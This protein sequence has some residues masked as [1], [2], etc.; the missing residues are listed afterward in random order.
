[1]LFHVICQ[2]PD[3][4]K[5]Y[6]YA[7]DHH[8]AKYQIL[9]HKQQSTGSKHFNYARDV[10]KYSSDRTNTHKNI[11]KCNPNKERKILIVFG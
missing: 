4:D 2:Q 3:V 9:I 5:I 6:L 11:E 10:I 1:M 8:K 7:K